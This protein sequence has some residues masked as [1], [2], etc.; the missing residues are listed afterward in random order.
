VREIIRERDKMYHALQADFSSEVLHVYKSE[1]NFLLIRVF[2][3]QQLAVL[4]EDFNRHGIKVLNTSNFPLMENTFRVSIGSAYENE[5][6][7]QCLLSCLPSRLVGGLQEGFR[8]LND[9]AVMN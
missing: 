1:G 4:M 7:Y 6:F 9:V 2:A 3:P 5:I 8:D